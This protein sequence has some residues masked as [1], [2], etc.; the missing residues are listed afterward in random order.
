MEHQEEIPGYDRN[1]AQREAESVAA[2]PCFLSDDEVV[3]A[4]FDQVPSR[5]RRACY[6]GSAASSAL[7][8]LAVTGTIFSTHQF[9]NAPKEAKLRAKV[10]YWPAASIDFDSSMLGAEGASR[11]DQTLSVCCLM[12]DSE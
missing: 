10:S 11:L 9:V 5:R 2:P 3:V 4:C 12:A 6:L 1:P 7:R 8:C